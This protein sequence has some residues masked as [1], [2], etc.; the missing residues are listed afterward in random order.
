MEF[1]SMGE[2]GGGGGCEG[3]G[4]DGMFPAGMGSNAL[5]IPPSFW[6]WRSSRGC[7]VCGTDTYR[8]PNVGFSTL[9]KWCCTG[10][11]IPAGL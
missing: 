1:R 9:G 3:V 4:E 11:A 8:L 10:S 7:S 2:K 6:P 5:L